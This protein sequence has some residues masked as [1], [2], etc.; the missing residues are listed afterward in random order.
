VANGSNTYSFT[1]T[2]NSSYVMWVRGNIPNGIIVW[3]AT[4]S[5]TNNNVPAIGDQFAWNYVAGNQ[6]LLTS[7]PNQ[8][9][10][11][12]GSIS[13]SAPAVANTNVF[14]F[15]ITNNSGANCVVDYG[16]IKIS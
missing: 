7:I 16:Y 5:L 6:L 2:D 15:D 8:I 12:S 13:N 10:G 9:I 4:V 3:N 11:T 14:A 1:V